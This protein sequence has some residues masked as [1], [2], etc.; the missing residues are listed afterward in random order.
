[1]FRLVQYYLFG[2]DSPICFLKTKVAPSRRANDKPHEPWVSIDK[3]KGGVIS[4]HCT[5]KA[6]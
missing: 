1:M 3:V 5:F 2:E 6:G 4:A